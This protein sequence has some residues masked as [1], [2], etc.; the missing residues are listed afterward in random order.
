MLTGRMCFH[1]DSTAETLVRVLDREPE[2][3][4][5]P[6]STPDHVRRV[7]ARCLR[8]SRQLRD[9]GDARLDLEMAPLTLAIRG[10]GVEAAAG[11]WLPP[12]RPC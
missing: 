10:I 6:S 7:L 3:D 2:W 4:R 1:G 12:R 8:T 11:E 9:L 5:L